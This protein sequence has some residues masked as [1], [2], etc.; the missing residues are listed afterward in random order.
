MGL[1]LGV[2]HPDIALTHVSLALPPLRHRRVDAAY[3]SY[4]DSRA[5]S[6]SGVMGQVAHQFKKTKDNST[7]RKKIDLVVIN[8]IVDEF[9]NLAE[10]INGDR[11]EVRETRSEA[12][13]VAAS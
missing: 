13:S 2:R 4:L 12:R 10:V 3:V 8:D 6:L 1:G 5:A 7:A 9:F 11:R